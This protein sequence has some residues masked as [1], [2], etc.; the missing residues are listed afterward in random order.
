MKWTFLSDESEKMM[1][2]RGFVDKKENLS[3]TI[4]ENPEEYKRNVEDVENLSPTIVEN[5]VNDPSCW[6]IGKLI[7]SW[8]GK[9]GSKAWSAISD[10][11]S[12]STVDKFVK[13]CAEVRKYLDVERMILVPDTQMR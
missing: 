5:S 10:D 9:T 13:K 4:V 8:C 12:T 1:I 2:D 7:Y 6:E 11:L 3:S